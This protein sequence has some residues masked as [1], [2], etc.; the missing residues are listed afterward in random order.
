MHLLLELQTVEKKE[1][2]LVDK[3]VEV[4]VLENNE[5]YYPLKQIRLNG[6]L[7]YVL[8]NINN[9]KDICVRKEIEEDGVMLISMLDSEEELRTVLSEYKKLVEN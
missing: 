5:K 6:V 1:V 7:Y 3:E 8:I 9:P 4:L 2:D